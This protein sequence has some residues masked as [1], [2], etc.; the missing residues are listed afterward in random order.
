MKGHGSKFTQKM[1]AAITG[2][3]TQKNQEEAARSAGISI[4]TL[5]RWQRDPEFQKAYREARRAE[6]GQAVARLQHATSAAV[7][8][9]LKVMVDPNTPPSVKVRVADSVLNHWAKSIELE[10]IDARLADLEIAAEA[11]H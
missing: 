4:A 9:L 10:D 7:T 1:E 5:I 6:H 8:T 11:P 3:I 2:L